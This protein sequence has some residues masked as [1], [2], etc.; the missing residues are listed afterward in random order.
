VDLVDARVVAVEPAYP[1]PAPAPWPGRLRR[2]VAAVEYGMVVV[3]YL[4]LFLPRFVITSDGK[5][6]YD[7]LTVLL[8]GHGL[9]A[10]RYQLVGPLFATPLWLLGHFHV[11]GRGPDR[12]VNHYNVALFGLALVT[13]FVLLR[14]RLDPVL[15]RRFLLLLV[16]GSMVPTHVT[17]FYGEIFTAVAVAVGIFV[18]VST[19]IHPVLRVAAWGATI[20]GTANTPATVPALGLT[21]A[22]RTA[23]TRRLRY[24]LP[25]VLAAAVVMTENWLRRGNPLDQGYGDDPGFTYPFLLGVLAILFSFG[26]GLVFFVPGLLLPVRR[27]MAPLYDAGRI[28]L[29]QGY[30]SLMLFVAGMVLVYASWWAWNGDTSWGPRFFLIAIFPAALAL[31]VWLTKRDERLLPTLAVLAILALSMWVGANSAAFDQVWPRICYGDMEYCRFDIVDSPLWYPVLMWPTHVGRRATVMLLYHA[32][33]FLWLAAPL[34]LTAVRAATRLVGARLH[35]LRPAG[36][37]W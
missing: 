23:R 35:V 30:L 32:G 36:W 27:R 14:K 1:E 19:G 18:V 37:H 21:G 12:W 4:V 20:L 5:H 7:A 26:K 6:R 2:G 15:L 10:D 9:S 13:L 16:A 25:P 29:R 11:A 28:D 17:N 3:G 31:A 24:L 22:E 34:V 33:V 8:A